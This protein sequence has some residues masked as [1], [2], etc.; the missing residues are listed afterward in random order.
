MAVRFL[1]AFLQ[2]SVPGSFTTGG[3]FQTI[4]GH[5]DCLADE[6]TEVMKVAAGA[7]T[8]SAS[9]GGG[10]YSSLSGGLWTLE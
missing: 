4:R 6:G 9:S 7:I 10:G 1:S 8:R 5:L 2:R 3:E